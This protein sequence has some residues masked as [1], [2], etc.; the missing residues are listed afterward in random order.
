MPTIERIR[1][2]SEIAKSDPRYPDNPERLVRLYADLAEIQLNELVPHDVRQLFETAKNLS[3]HTWY[4]YRF[5]PIATVIGYSA[6]EA[7]LRNRVAGDPSFPKSAKSEWFPSFKGMLRHAVDKDWIR[8]EGFEHARR[9]A[10]GRARYKSMIASIEGNPEAERIQIPDPTPEEIDAELEELPYARKMV[11][12]TPDIRNAI[13]HGEPLL[14]NASVGALRKTAE[15]INQLFEPRSLA[16]IGDAKAQMAPDDDWHL[17]E[18][19]ST[20]SF[21]RPPGCWVAG[22]PAIYFLWRSGSRSPLYIGKY[23]S[24]Q[25]YDVYRRVSQ[26]C[27]GS[28]TLA[29][30]RPTLEAFGGQIPKSLQAYI[31]R[32]DNRFN[33]PQRRK[34]LES[35]VIRVVCHER[36]MQDRHFA[37]IKSQ[38]PAVEHNYHELADAIVAR[39]QKRAAWTS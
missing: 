34:S 15:A 4:V 14:D 20:G 19:T 17:V 30:L 3:L 22:T 28:G 2:L 21:T 24:A 37:V 11:D 31:F 32:L 7:A 16:L 13:A 5:H 36:K 12:N 18:F 8:N 39:F 25:N 6:L 1:P 9:I 23:G 27:K 38:R 10:E 29:R 33:D 35:W 26:H